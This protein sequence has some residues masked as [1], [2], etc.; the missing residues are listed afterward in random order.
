[1]RP[2]QVFPMLMVGAAGCLDLNALQSGNG[3]DMGTMPKDLAMQPDM[4]MPGQDMLMPPDM[5][6]PPDFMP[7]ASAWSKVYDSTGAPLNAISGV[8]V[9]MTDSIYA[10]GN[11]GTT[12]LGDGTT[13]NKTATTPPTG[14]TLN[15]V[16]VAG[17]LEA[18]AAS[19][20]GKV[21]Q[22]TVG[23]TLWTDKG[24]ALNPALRGI[25]AKNNSNTDILAAGDEKNNAGHWNG[26]NWV[27][28]DH[29]Q[30]KKTYGVW[31]SSTKFY[32]VGEM[33]RG[34]ISSDPRAAMNP[35]K[36]IDNY[37]NDL[38]A[39]SGIDDNNVFAVSSNG[40]LLKY[41]SAGN[42]WDVN[43]SP[44]G[45]LVALSII[46]ATEIWVAGNNGGNGVVFKCDSVAK[47]CLGQSNANLNQ[48]TLTG[49]WGNPK[50]VMYVTAN[51][52]GNGA[53]LKY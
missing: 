3:G 49:I 23:G 18:W 20:T 53:I 9:A 39:V 37:P 52:G 41:D 45:T 2:N 6:I 25:Y 42:K 27:S 47:T 30:N 19:S 4:A 21:F 12:V 5:T 34:M 17:A 50:S 26:T 1:M 35:W 43:A 8:T 51:N 28:S 15:A 29:S 22:G 32:L 36:L 7:P 13:F 24:K 33:G 10:V 16:W 48:Q 46:S 31:G 11:G 44:G 40:N 14:E 38:N